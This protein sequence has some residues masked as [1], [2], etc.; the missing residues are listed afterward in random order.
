MDA[1]TSNRVI[2]VFL[3]SH[4][5]GVKVSVK[6]APHVEAFFQKWGGGGQE[7]P[8]AGRL[9]K[10]IPARSA[11]DPPSLPIMVWSFIGLNRDNER[12][13][14]GLSGGPLIVDDVI[15]LSCLRLVGASGDAGVDF[16]CDMVI[17]K[18]ELKRIADR[19]LAASEQFYGEYLQSV[20][21]RISLS[22]D[23]VR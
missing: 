23:E 3:R 22:V 15:N 20:G 19:F 10:P 13:T 8:T 9:W 14:L 1:S 12:Y 4:A 5:D 11:D 6:V 16:I 18:T 17:S 2:N 21:M 7:R